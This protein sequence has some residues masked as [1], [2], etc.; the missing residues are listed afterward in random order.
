MK[1]YLDMIEDTSVPPFSNY[2]HIEYY[3]FG[4]NGFDDDLL[5]LKDKNLHLVDLT[6]MFNV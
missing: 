6:K 1:D 5:L 3:L 4:S 2:K